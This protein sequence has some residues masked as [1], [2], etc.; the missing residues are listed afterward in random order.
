MAK[1]LYQESL[2][3]FSPSVY[4]RARQAICALVKDS[5]AQLTEL[6]VQIESDLHSRRRQVPSHL[7]FQN[8][9]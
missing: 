1:Q 6:L 4:L 5:K 9:H 2:R 3:M 7:L 8:L